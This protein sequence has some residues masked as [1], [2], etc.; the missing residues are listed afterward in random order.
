MI[1]VL[2]GNQQDLNMYPTHWLQL[3]LLTGARSYASKSTR[4]LLQT[5][6]SLF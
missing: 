2:F 3:P 1:M 4:C 6:F 5:V